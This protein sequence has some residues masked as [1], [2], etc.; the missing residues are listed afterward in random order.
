MIR[1]FIKACVEAGLVHT[2][3]SRLWGK[4][5]NVLVLLYHN[6]VPDHYEVRGEESLHVRIADFVEQME[7]LA[8]ECRVVSLDQALAQPRS[9]PEPRVA[10]T[11]DDAYRGAVDLGIPHLTS[12][13]IPCTLFVAPGILDSVGMWWD[14]Y[15]R[16]LDHSDGDRSF[17]DRALQDTAADDPSVDALAQG[18]SVASSPVGPYEGIV[19]ENDILTLAESNQVTL[20]PHSWSHRNLSTASEAELDEELSRPRGWF[21]ER[22]V[23]AVPWMAYPYG[24]T[25]RITIQR[26]QDTGYEGGLLAAGGW[27]RTSDRPSKFEIPRLSIPRG[28]SLNGFRLRLHG[29]VGSD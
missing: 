8:R 28:L 19:G 18:M 15:A 10:I 23:H 25:S 27:M 13:G 1:S 9:D 5:R 29:V 21:Q 4:N 22:N 11:F 24:L 20:A 12:R 17:R 7:W 2:G 3:I 26:A 16:V 14:R 6:V